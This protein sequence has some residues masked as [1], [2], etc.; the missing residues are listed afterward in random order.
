M[1]LK[2]LL[3]IF[4]N[5]TKIILKLYYLSLILAF[6]IRINNKFEGELDRRVM[7]NLIWFLSFDYNNSRFIVASTNVRKLTL[8]EA[9]FPLGNKW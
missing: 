5:V 4:V 6:H 1:N 2:Y 7:E 8:V 3:H 9:N